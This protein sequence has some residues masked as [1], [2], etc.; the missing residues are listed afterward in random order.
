MTNTA[1]AQPQLSEIIAGVAETVSEKQAEMDALAAKQAELLAEI[2]AEKA[3]QDAIVDEA[4]AEYRAKRDEVQAG[5]VERKVAKAEALAPFDARLE[6][7]M[8]KY[9][10][11]KAAAAEPHDAAITADMAKLAE[12]E[13]SYA[14]KLGIL[15]VLLN[16]DQAPAP[17]AAKASKTTA[18]KV[19]KH[20]KVS[21]LGLVGP[22]TVT[23]PHRYSYNKTGLSATCIYEVKDVTLEDGTVVRELFAKRVDV[24]KGGVSVIDQTKV[25]G[26]YTKHSEVASLVT[27]APG[28]HHTPDV[29]FAL[30]AASGILGNF[31]ELETESAMSDVLVNGEALATAP[32]TEAEVTIEEVV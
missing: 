18:G 12:L 32:A 16:K 22:V 7:Y 23:A 17:A 30:A 4:C 26:A 13:D 31:P 24:T 6:K 10:A 27:S 3:S 25:E 8:A 20:P 9:N 19:R 29:M 1:A 5:I 15:P 2:A 14:S 21:D 28:W 11:E